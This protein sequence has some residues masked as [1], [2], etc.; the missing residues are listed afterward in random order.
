MIYRIT[1]MGIDIY[2]LASNR[3]GGFVFLKLSEQA[4]KQLNMLIF[5]S[6]TDKELLAYTIGNKVVS[7]RPI[8]IYKKEEQMIHLK[9]GQNYQLK[10]GDMLIYEKDKTCVIYE[11]GKLQDLS[12]EQFKKKSRGISKKVSAFC[13]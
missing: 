11:N 10:E 3:S 9:P 12:Y 13:E 1:P 2:Q 8:L 7:K 6:N 5:K 4:K